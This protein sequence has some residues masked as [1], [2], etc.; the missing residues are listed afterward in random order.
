MNATVTMAHDLGI[1]V[2]AEG[3]EDENALKLLRELGCDRAQGYYYS[4]PLEFDAFIDWMASWS[5][6]G[7][8]N[9]I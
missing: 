5:K 1:C 2:V 7:K 9:A 3:V 6:A 8:R 4:Q